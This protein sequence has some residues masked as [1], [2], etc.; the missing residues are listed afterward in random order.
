M[1]KHNLTQ[2]RR[3]L[4]SL[5][6]FIFNKLEKYFFRPLIIIFPLKKIIKNLEIEKHLRFIKLGTFFASKSQGG[7]TPL[8]ESVRGWRMSPLPPPCVRPWL[9]TS[10]LLLATTDG[11]KL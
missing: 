2:C 11:I 4:T 10:C 8:P 9:K 1:V 7:A 3:I 6:I 5:V